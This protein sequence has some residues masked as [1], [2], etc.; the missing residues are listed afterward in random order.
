MTALVLERIRDAT[1]DLE[2]AV[3]F[4]EARQERIATPPPNATLERDLL[5]IARPV[6]SIVRAVLDVAERYK[7]WLP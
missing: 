5:S 7:R 3:G 2:R 4:L 6:L 1:L